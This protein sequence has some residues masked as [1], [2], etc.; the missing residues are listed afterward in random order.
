MPA[1]ILRRTV[2]TADRHLELN[3]RPRTKVKHVLTSEALARLRKESAE[4]APATD[5]V[6]SRLDS[7]SVMLREAKTIQETKKILDAVTAASI[8]AK[9]QG[10]SDEII[11]QAHEIRIRA[12]EQLGKMLAATQLSKGGGP[13][14]GKKGKKPVTPK[15]PVFRG[16]HAQRDWRRQKNVHGGPADRRTP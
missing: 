12:F 5:L 13:G 6:V 15:E 9:R 10:L 2:A 8:Y 11:G 16:A 4:N 1:R 7:A 14:R 3:A